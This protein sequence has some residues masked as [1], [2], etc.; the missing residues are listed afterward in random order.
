MAGFLLRLALVYPSFFEYRH[1]THTHS[2]IAMLGWG[3]TILTA[4]INHSFIKEDILLKKYKILGVFTQLTIIGMLCS[5]PFQGY[6]WM[7]ITFSSFFLLSTYIY[8]FFVLKNT[9]TEAKKEIS[10]DFLKISLFFLVFSGIGIWLLPVSIA[11]YG[12]NSAQYNAAIYFFLHFQYNG[13]ILSVLAAF[14]LKYIEKKSLFLENSRKILTFAYFLAILGSVCLSWTELFNGNI[15]L[16]LIGGGSVLLLLYLWGELMRIYFTIKEKKDTFLSV[17]LILFFIKTL[18]LGLSA[19]PSLAK[20]LFFNMDLV[21]AYLHFTFLGVM[22][23]GIC[24][25][26]KTFFGIYF[27][28]WVLFSYFLAFLITEALIGYKGL[29]IWFNL[30]FFGSYFKWLAAASGLFLVSAGAFFYIIV[31]TKALP[32]RKANS[33]NP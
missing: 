13:F 6:G 33:V 12:K 5:F 20:Q 31:K 30:P 23:V 9:K 3:Y 14:F 15:V 21:I 32:N 11:L 18:F 27:P 24:F 2:H 28:K 19:I 7:S 29:A 22:F 25:V 26:L 16:Y 1:L 4:F 17:F 10:Y 8:C